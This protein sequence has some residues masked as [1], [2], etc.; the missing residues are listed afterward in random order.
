MGEKLPDGLLIRN[1]RTSDY[2]K[3]IKALKYWW[4]GRDLT[5]MVPRLFLIHFSN[6]SFIVEK[7]NRFIAFLIG[8][9]SPD[10]PAEGYIHFVG[11][12]PDFRK[13]GIGKVL[14][15]RFFKMCKENNR[16]TVRSCTSPVNKG[17]IEF[18]KKIGFEISEGNA[19]IEGI[20]ITLDYNGPNDPKVLF[21]INIRALS[22]STNNESGKCL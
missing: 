7:N 10:R 5:R 1:P 19:E 17:S 15:N 2:R 11:V 14:Y 16:D 20:Q 21:E 22:C 8:F 6:T 3:I 9:L 13:T 4:D 18:H 12:H